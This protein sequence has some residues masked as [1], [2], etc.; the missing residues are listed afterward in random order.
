MCIFC[1]FFL[2]CL[3]A[4][5]LM[6]RDPLTQARFINL[7]L[8]LL[9][10][11]SKIELVEAQTLFQ[12]SQLGLTFCCFRMPIVATPS[13]SR[14]KGLL[15]MDCW[16]NTSFPNQC[17]N[18]FFIY[19]SRVETWFWALCFP[20]C[21]SYSFLLNECSDAERVNFS[22]V[23]DLKDP[24]ITKVRYLEASLLLVLLCCAPHLKY[25]KVLKLVE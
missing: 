4:E 3:L 2:L 9:L 5:R 21:L 22:V 16:K 18:I 19:V 23:A 10:L 7:V 20:A 24:L 25:N 1:R 6:K 14:L 17:K 15:R 12:A 8:E 11:L 13:W